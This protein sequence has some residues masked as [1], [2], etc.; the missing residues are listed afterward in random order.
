MLSERT[1][2]MIKGSLRSIAASVP[3]AASLSQAWNE[4]EARE[5]DRRIES[6]FVEINSVVEKCNERLRAVEEFIKTSQEFPALL[7]KTVEKVQSEPSA[8]KRRIHAVTLVNCIGTGTTRSYGDKLTVIETLDFLTDEDIHVLNRF[9]DSTKIQV[10]QMVGSFGTWTEEDAAAPL[11]PI[12][13]S[14]SKL[15]SRGLI[16]ESSALHK[17]FASSGDSNHWVN[18][19]RRK[20]YELIPFGQYFLEMTTQP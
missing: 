14:L 1:E 20:T 18:R 6:F 12:I 17:P 10:A 2:A 16:S 13:V 19:W 5:K 9:R 3:V 7:E 8:D 11:A 15:E 4:F